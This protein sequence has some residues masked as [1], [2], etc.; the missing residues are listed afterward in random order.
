MEQYGTASVYGIDGLLYLQI[1]AGGTFDAMKAYPDPLEVEDRTAIDE[2]ISGIGKFIGFRKFDEREF[3]TFTLVAKNAAT[4]AG[5]AGTDIDPAIKALALPPV[6]SAIRWTP[7]LHVSE[8]TAFDLTTGGGPV[9]GSVDYLYIGGGRRTQVN[10]RNGL[11]LVGFRNKGAS[12]MTVA[13]LM[14]KAT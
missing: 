12:D 7:T 11:V 14:V 9:A 8:T 1:V 2:F 5:A 4:G 10:G 13:Q 3:A 6:P